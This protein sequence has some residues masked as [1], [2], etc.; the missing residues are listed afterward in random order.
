MYTV[1]TRPLKVME[2]FSTHCVLYSIVYVHTVYTYV[3][4]LEL[5]V[6]ALFDT[7]GGHCR[8]STLTTA[9][10]HSG[11]KRWNFP[12]NSSRSPLV[13][14]WMCKSL[15]MNWLATTGECSDVIKKKDHLDCLS[16]CLPISAT[17]FVCHMHLK[18]S[19]CK[20]IHCSHTHL[21][22]YVV[23]GATKIPLFLAWYPP[24]LY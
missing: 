21:P 24:L 10:S 7:Q 12:W 22:L 2:D 6:H 15:I 23:A 4:L 18:R 9:W 5:S 1:H 3:Y 16:H 19:E 11:M 20:R 14:S 17:P 8:Q 13:T